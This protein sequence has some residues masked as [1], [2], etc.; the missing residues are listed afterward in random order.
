MKCNHGNIYTISGRSWSAATTEGLLI[1]SLDNLLTFDPVD[2]D[3]DI[4]PDNMR[5]AIKSGR[6]SQLYNL[7][8]F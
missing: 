3:T 6:F 1:Y 4:T 5:K 7:H 2:L 8:S